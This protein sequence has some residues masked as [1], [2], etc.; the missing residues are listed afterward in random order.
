MALVLM[1]WLPRWGAHAYMDPRSG[2]GDK[3]THVSHLFI[4]LCA[5]MCVFSMIGD[6]RLAS[7]P[8]TGSGVAVGNVRI[9][10]SYVR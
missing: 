3:H 6:A 10:F 4:R 9:N 8:I 7:L 2:A 5:R 1:A